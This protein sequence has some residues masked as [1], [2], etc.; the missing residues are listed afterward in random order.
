MSTPA[1]PAPDAG[2]PGADV[3]V[4]IAEPAPTAPEP[5]GAPE[6][7]AP[8][9]EAP[10]APVGAPEAPPAPGQG[11][12]EP[13]APAGDGTDTPATEVDQLPEW[14]QK[15]IRELREENKRSRLETKQAAVDEATKA[16]RESFAQDI[17][18]ALGLIPT[19]E[20]GAAEEPLTAEQL[21][22]L[23][24]SE[25]VS[26]QNAKVELAV[27]R[28]AGT[29]N[30]D[31]SALLDSRA[32][33]DALKNVDP[34]DSDSINAAIREAVANNPRLKV[35]EPAPAADPTPEPTPPPSGGTFAG[36]PSGRGN[37]VSTMSIEDFRKQYKEN[38]PR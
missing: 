21:T 33:L 25:R 6:S 1:A 24:A 23:L 15:H 18:K 3:T 31:P 2:A 29:H 32:F 20:P 14:A 10:A 17:G 8:A 16:A 26:T 7:P 35:P 34:S 30:A 27:F 9:P 36:G 12:P 38:R 22:E 5:T 13:T 11:Q 37:D 28:S 19:E 4:T